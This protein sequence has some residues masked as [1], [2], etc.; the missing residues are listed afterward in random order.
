MTMMR[1]WLRQPTWT[2]RLLSGLYRHVQCAYE[3]HRT[4]ITPF[5]LSVPVISVGGLTVG[6]SGKTPCVLAINA[7]IRAQGY[8]CIMLTR[9]YKGTSKR[10]GFVQPEDTPLSAGE[11]AFIL[12]QHGPVFRSKDILS[13]A[14]VLEAYLNNQNAQNN[15]VV[16]WDDGH[17]YPKL[18]KD[19]SLIV[20]NVEQ[21]WA[22]SALFPAG[23]LREDLRPGLARANMV[24]CLY[25]QSDCTRYHSVDTYGTPIAPI[26][27]QQTCALPAYTRVVGFCG[28]GDPSRFHASLQRHGLEVCEFRTFG[29]H[30]T[31]TSK[32]EAQLIHLAAQHQ[33]TLITSHKDYVKLSRSM[34]DTTYQMLQHLTLPAILTDELR[35]I[36]ALAQ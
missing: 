29:D 23:P 19:F 13:G 25:F 6:G 20:T 9:G 26:L 4:P 18:H 2:M 16:V 15:T 21:K 28:L 14:H 5:K 32:D 22:N 36:L 11:E 10:L 7:W 34:R 33:A 3:W 8:Q 24:A 1:S 31:Y 30:H 35:R 17:Q 27:C 12:A